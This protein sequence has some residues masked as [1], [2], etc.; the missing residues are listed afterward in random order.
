MIKESY[1]AFLGVFLSYNYYNG[2]VKEN[3]I[4][5]N[6]PIF[7]IIDLKRQKNNP[8]SHKNKIFLVKLAKFKV[9]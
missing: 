7:K 5:V 3:F 6:I 1:F 4:F 8:E 9:F 2:A